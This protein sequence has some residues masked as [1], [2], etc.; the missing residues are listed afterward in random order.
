MQRKPGS[1]KYRSFMRLTGLAG[2]VLIQPDLDRPASAL[3]WRLVAPLRENGMRGS[4][5][6][7]VRN[8]S[9]LPQ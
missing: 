2:A 9:S 6:G 1:G 7:G 4:E 8:G 3:P 5:E